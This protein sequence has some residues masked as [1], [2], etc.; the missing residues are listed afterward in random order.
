MSVNFRDIQ[1]AANRIAGHVIQSPCPFSIPLSEATGLKVFCKL[2]YLQRTGSFK[3]RGAR[4]ALTLLSPEQK[5]RGVIAASAGNHALGLAYHGQLLGIPVTVVMPRFAPLTKVTNCRRLGANVVMH[6]NDMGEARARADE[7]A[8]EQQLACIN[9]YDDPAII[10]GQGTLGLEIAAQVPEVDAVIMPIGGAGLVAGVALALKTLKPKVK[11]LGVEP[12]RAAS[13]TAA[14]AAGHP[15]AVETRPTLADGLSIPK[16]GENAFALARGLVDNTLLVGEREIALAILRLLEL[17]KAV[18]EGAG[19]APLAACLA[20]LAPE[21]KGKNVVLPLSGGNI[22]TPIL[23]KVLERGLASDG[24]LYRFTAT[25]SDRPGGLARFA[26]LIAETGAS[27]IEIAHD[28]AFSSEDINT[29]NVHCVVETRDAEHIAELS[30]RLSS[31]GF[32]IAP[33][34]GKHRESREEAHKSQ[35]LQPK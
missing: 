4:N 3:E 18:V 5:K 33:T 22:D 13:F 2:E 26:S 12:E 34:E 17:E 35:K 31:A 25:I 7:L 1:E 20:G 10:A 9:G 15:V 27:I 16:V 28:R 14:V 6:G 24:R 19:A 23:G 21:L 32:I 11:V 29:V 8:R 30:A